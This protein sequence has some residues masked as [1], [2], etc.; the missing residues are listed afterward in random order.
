VYYFTGEPAFQIP[1]RYEPVTGR[2]RAGYQGEYCLMRKRLREGG[3]LL[4]L[5]GPGRSIPEMDNPEDLVRGMT[6]VVE[7]PDG[8]VF[9]D[10]SGTLQGCDPAG[11]LEREPAAAHVVRILPEE[12]W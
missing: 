12:A 6:S 11:R 8:A 5:F 4:V 7:G 1:L 10:G 9:R 3:G 2:E